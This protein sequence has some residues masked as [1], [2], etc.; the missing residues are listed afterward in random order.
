MRVTRASWS[1]WMPGTTSP[2]WP[3]CWLTCPWS[4]AAGSAPTGCCASP[5]RHALA[6]PGG[7]RRVVPVRARRP[8]SAAPTT[9]VRM[10]AP[11]GRNLGG[12][13]RA[14]ANLRV[15]R[16]RL[17]GCMRLVVRC[18]RPSAPHGIGACASVWVAVVSLRDVPPRY[19]PS[20]S[21]VPVMCPRP[22]A[23]ADRGRLAPNDEPADHAA[24]HN[25][26]GHTTANH[27][28]YQR[29]HAGTG[30][31]ERPAQDG[32]AARDLNPEPAD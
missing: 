4:C 12:R 20:T 24:T 21:R 32:C 5:R 15:H 1:C 19:L 27:R 6:A 30:C 10:S 3:G 8:D 14:G 13:H 31:W 7:P 9:A 11:Q 23:L 28:P 25:A 26:P 22:H 18:R 17:P 2:R 16:P 29:R